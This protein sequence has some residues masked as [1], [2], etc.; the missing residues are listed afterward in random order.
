[1]LTVATAAKMAT[2][3][4]AT[5]AMMMTDINDRKKLTMETSAT[6]TGVDNGNGYPLLPRVWQLLS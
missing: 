6:M 2:M 4:A 5:T 1:M 3:A